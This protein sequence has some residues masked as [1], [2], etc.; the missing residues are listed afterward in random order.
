M[1]FIGHRWCYN[2]QA[3]TIF[4]GFAHD[5]IVKLSEKNQVKV[6]TLTVLDFY[7]GLFYLLENALGFTIIFEGWS[8]LSFVLKVIINSNNIKK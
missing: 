1:H 3:F 6:R 8:R 4:K 5:L 7:F 2:V